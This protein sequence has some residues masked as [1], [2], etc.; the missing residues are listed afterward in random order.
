[1]Y[2]ETNF[3]RSFETCMQLASVMGIC[4]KR[5]CA[6]WMAR[7]VLLILTRL[8]RV[9]IMQILRVTRKPLRVLLPVFD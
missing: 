6:V 9:V 7:Q 4:G 1:V 2:I 5:T 8:L 3:V